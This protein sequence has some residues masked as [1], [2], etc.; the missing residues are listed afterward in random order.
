M[1]ALR[2][3]GTKVFEPV[4]RFTLNIPEDC[5]GDALGTIG[6]H[7]GLVGANELD[8]N[9]WRIAGT[10]PSSEVHAFEQR[11]PG[12]SHGEGDFES[13]FDSFAPVAGSVPTRPRT[14]FNPLDRKYYLAQ[15]SQ[16]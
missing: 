5:I 3:A 4:E 8:G 10:I 1:E 15:V 2:Q 13:R 6:A 7:R 9:G 14:D 16:S 12:V 11:L